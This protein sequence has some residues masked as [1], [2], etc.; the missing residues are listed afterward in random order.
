MWNAPLTEEWAKGHGAGVFLKL[1]EDLGSDRHSEVV[2]NRD[3]V[4][5]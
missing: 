5:S 2:V 3:T 1:Y 4:R